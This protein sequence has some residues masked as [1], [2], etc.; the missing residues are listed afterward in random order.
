MTAAANE[1]RR[2]TLCVVLHA[3]L[4][5]VLGHG[6]W[7]HGEEWLWE[8]AAECY[9]PLLDVLL[10]AEE[11]GWVGARAK[12]SI[13]WTPV[14]LEML[15]NPRFASG[16][17]DYL[18]RKAEYAADDEAAFAESSEQAH[19][20]PLAKRW[21]SLYRTLSERFRLVHER[22]LIGSLRRLHDVG[23]FQLLG[24]PATH[25]YGPL[26]SSWG[27][28][29]FQY[30]TGAAVTRRHFGEQVS[31]AWLP[32]CAY[33]PAG[34]FQSGDGAVHRASWG[35]E[36]VLAAAGF[37]TTFVDGHLLDR[38]QL[39]SGKLVAFSP[40]GPHAHPS[41]HLG[42]DAPRQPEGLA[43]AARRSSPELHRAHGV[44]D[45][46]SG[47]CIF[48][49]D[50]KTAEQVWS[51]RI[52]YPAAPVYREFHKRHDPGGHRYWAVT[53][54][55][56]D[57]GDK[58]PYEPDAAQR[59]AQQDA[60]DFAR[61]L[62]RWILDDARVEHPVYCAP[63]DAELFGHW[64]S[65]GPAFL[66]AFLHESERPHLFQTRTVECELDRRP[67]LDVLSLEAGSWGEGGD[68]RVWQGEHAT[69][70]WQRLE[71]GV[72][73]VQSAVARVE[74][75]FGRRC[76]DQAARSL[77]LGSASDWPFLVYGGT[78][79]DYAERR[80]AGHSADLARL[81][82]LAGGEPSSEAETELREFEERDAAF[83][84][85]DVRWILESSP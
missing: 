12:L 66:R 67:P 36:H 13:G 42:V 68:H 15:A 45:P 53:D 81:L 18:E 30:E 60:A 37:H 19:L 41:S 52:G 35:M 40:L 14:L 58:K 21:R 69:D 57:L 28:L 34:P 77:L 39:G 7:P 32:E 65:E 9:L 50:P 62:D 49:R 16:F 70:F 33:R 83:A 2:G 26:C 44:G 48:G 10:E 8:A 73:A 64:W 29:R 59:R 56:G 5:W 72:R 78:A 46:G 80:I 38:H 20:V 17:E 54:P 31:A 1:A 85:L 22:D 6:T 71:S 43:T 11:R 23:A 4:P 76:V 63:Y 75:E 84:D 24:G 82:E 74:G 27:F 25:P 3:H 79:A 47:V 51:G 55:G 61:R